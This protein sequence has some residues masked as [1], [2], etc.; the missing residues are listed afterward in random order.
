MPR[1]STSASARPATRTATSIRLHFSRLA[2]PSPPV[3]RSAHFTNPRGCSEAT[4]DRCTGGSCAV[5]GSGCRECTGHGRTGRSGSRGF[6]ADARHA[7]APGAGQG[8]RACAGAS[9]RRGAVGSDNRG[10][11]AASLCCRSGH[12]P[13]GRADPQRARTRAHLESGSSRFTTGSR[14]AAAARTRSAHTRAAR[15]LAMRASAAPTAVHAHV[16]PLPVSA[17]EVGRGAKVVAGAR[18]ASGAM[19]DA[20]PAD[21][22]LQP[23]SAADD[24][25]TPH[26]GIRY[27]IAA[28]AV[29]GCSLRP[30]GDTRDRRPPTPASGIG[31][32][33]HPRG[34]TYHFWRCAST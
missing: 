7:T 14:R 30:R 31:P 21:R 1:T 33:G 15:P 29:G 16:G 20:R 28:L 11:P 10:P 2:R 12:A 32:S 24:P 5:A 8:D 26:A 9:R 6:A 23:L 25:G 4:H 34:D 27:G 3:R 19:A 13:P 18:R 22:A 17:A